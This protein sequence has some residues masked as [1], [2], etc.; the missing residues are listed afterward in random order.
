M[1]FPG[2]ASVLLFFQV[3]QVEWEPCL[4]A[5]IRCQYQWGVGEREGVGTH[6]PC[7]EEGWNSEGGMCTVESNEIIMATWDHPPTSGYTHT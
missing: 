5:T 6:V 7:L 4:V 1:I 2:F 3:F